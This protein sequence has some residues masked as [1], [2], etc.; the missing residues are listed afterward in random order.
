MADDVPSRLARPDMS[1]AERH[2]HSENVY[3]TKGEREASWFEESPAL[4]LD[5]IRAT[6][7]AI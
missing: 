6:G 4:S 5:L 1:D 3:Q 2:A 7:A